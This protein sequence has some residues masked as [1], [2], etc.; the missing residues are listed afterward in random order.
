MVT[1]GVAS[2][3]S[4]VNNIRQFNNEITHG[5]FM[6]A[7]TEIFKKQYAVKEDVSC[8]FFRAV[9]EG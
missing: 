1:K 7:V 3:R 5:T 2:V 8:V 9:L 4:P 6:E